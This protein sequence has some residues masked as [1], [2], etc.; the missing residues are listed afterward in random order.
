[1]QCWSGVFFVDVSLNFMNSYVS[2]IGSYTYINYVKYALAAG[3]VVK[4][5]VSLFVEIY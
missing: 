5:Q 3:L 1:M 4:Y 2:A